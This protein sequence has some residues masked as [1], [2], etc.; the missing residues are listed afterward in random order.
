MSLIS[1]RGLGQPLGGY[2]DDPFSYD[3]FF[4]DPFASAL[5]TPFSTALTSPFSSA[6]TSPFYGPMQTGSI[7][8]AVDL[9]EDDTKYTIRVDVPGYEKDQINVDVQGN[10]VVITGQQQSEDER[11]IGFTHRRE[12]RSSRFRRSVWLPTDFDRDQI[13]A[14]VR[15]GVLEVNVPKVNVQANRITVE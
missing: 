12:R 14:S 15:G 3:P 8:P 5:T 6:L 2:Y 9:F 10:R 13:K 11:D 1:R 7:I 4:N